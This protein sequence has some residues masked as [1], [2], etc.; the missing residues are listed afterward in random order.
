MSITTYREFTCDSCGAID[1]ITIPAQGSRPPQGPPRSAPA[2]WIA[3]VTNG[4]NKD[5]C[6]G[7]AVAK[8]TVKFR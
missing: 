2:D 6:K 8:V 7:C 3:I 4:V 5:V 1:R